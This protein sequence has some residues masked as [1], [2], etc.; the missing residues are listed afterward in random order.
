MAKMIFSNA[1][2]RAIFDA[3]EGGHA[4]F[5]DLMTDVAK[6][7]TIYNREGN[8]VSKE[9]ANNKIREVMFSVLGLEADTKDRRAIRRAIRRHK[10]DVFEVIENTVQDMLVSGW[11]D[12]PFFNEFVETK[13]A[14][15][16]DTNEFY[17]E[18]NVI[19][20][21]SE[22]SGNHHNLIRQRLGE[23]QSFPVRTSWYGLKVYAEYERF[24]TGNI[25][26][27]MFIQKVYEAVDKKVN[28][29]VYAALGSVGSELSTE[30]QWI[31]NGPLSDST[32]DKF[33][34]LVEDVQTANGTEVV[35][36]GT[37][38]ALSK[39]TALEKVEWISEDMKKERNTTGRVG[40]F[41]GIKLV[42]IPQVF[43][44][45]D[46]TTKLVSSTKLMVMP[47]ADNKF[48]KVFDEGD[49]QVKEISDGDTNV[50]KTIEYEYQ[51]KMGVAVVIGRKFGIW[52]IT[53]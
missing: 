7:K 11:G 41:E 33:V 20:T 52:N 13:S 15:I 43:A 14:A 8:E 35:V 34:T 32:K 50:D 10:I 28:S 36:M 48:I 9:D 2:T 23:G 17:T 26:W 4:T 37:K 38:S 5:S 31:K 47:V 24:M 39:I 27:A 21:V 49:A 25:D 40:Y 29:M 46:T 3:I 30:S 12:N 1:D 51:L 42:E 22:L 19:L 53:A 18:D 16:G 6:G 45:G 44:D